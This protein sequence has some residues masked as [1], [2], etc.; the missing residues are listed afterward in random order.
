ML[1]LR[2]LAQSSADTTTLAP[3][4][5]PHVWTLCASVSKRVF[6]WRKLG[7]GFSLLA[8]LPGAAACVWTWS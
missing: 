6:V 8:W 1:F 4:E 3:Q 5:M 7:Q 2:V